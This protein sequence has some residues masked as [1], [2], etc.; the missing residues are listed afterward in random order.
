MENYNNNIIMM[1]YGAVLVDLNNTVKKTIY[2]LVDSSSR[3][4]GEL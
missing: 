2:T 1:C 4:D 3:K